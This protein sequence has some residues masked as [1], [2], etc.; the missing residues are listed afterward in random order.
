MFR[1]VGNPKES[2]PL[3][4]KHNKPGI[5]PKCAL[6]P[7]TR[8]D[9][10]YPLTQGFTISLSI[11]ISSS[12]MLKPQRRKRSNLSTSYAE[13]EFVKLI[14]IVEVCLQPNVCK[15]HKR[16]A[17]IVEPMTAAIN[18]KILQWN[19]FPLKQ[20]QVSAQQQC[21]STDNFQSRNLVSYAANEH[22]ILITRNKQICATVALRPRHLLWP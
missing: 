8:S 1:F 5:S 10:V 11:P 14:L 13:T 22:L 15:K 12:T 4:L 16:A 20:T 2:T 6:L 3:S 7:T 21:E 19:H 17:S 18:H 9:P